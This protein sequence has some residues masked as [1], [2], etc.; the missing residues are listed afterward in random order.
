MLKKVIINTISNYGLK[1]VQ[2]LLNLL[3]IPILIERFGEEGFGIILFAGVVVGY[4]NILE[5]GFSSGVTK[6]VSQYMILNDFD[7]LNKIINTSLNFFIRIGLVVAIFIISWSLLGGVEWLDVDKTQLEN[8][9]IVFILAG[10]IAITAWPQMLLKSVFKGLQDFVFLNFTLA[11]GRVVSVLLALLASLYSDLSIIYVFLLFNLDKIVLTLWQFKALKKRIPFWSFSIFSFDKG[12]FKFM[13]SFSGWIML[14]QIAILLEYQADQLIIVSF[15]SVSE[16]ATYSVIFYLFSIIQQISGL[17]ASTVM[18]V[19]S[20]INETS[21][22]KQIQKFILD[23][24]RIHNLIF[25]PITILLFF[26]AEPFIR[27]WM[28][29]KYLEHI[30]FI[31]LTIV[32]QLF[33]QSSAMFGQLYTGLGFSKKPG[34]AAIIIGVLNVLLS[35]FL[36]EHM[37]VEGVVLGTIIIGVIAVPFAVSWYLRDVDIKP[38]DYFFNTLFKTQAPLI[39]AGSVLFM[40]YDLI[41]K[42]NS[43]LELTFVS[44]SILIYLVIIIFF[45]VLNKKQRKKI[46]SKF[47]ILSA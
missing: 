5:L 39:I 7:R 13:F 27:L 4:F 14:A 11:V 24:V 23:A 44:V 30:N 22:K 2:L 41:L 37:G 1:G 21:D 36:V 9:K 6:Y 31:R 28:G 18:P 20:Q 42:I 45:I 43:W 10:F 16:I 35:I 46:E 34:I 38:K 29:G 15:L 17:A 32:F 25:V 40:V 3:A 8:Y 12:T 47:G 26:I 19:M 33:W